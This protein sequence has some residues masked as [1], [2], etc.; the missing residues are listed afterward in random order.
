MCAALFGVVFWDAFLELTAL[1]SMVGLSAGDTE[2]KATNRAHCS[3]ARL[4]L[5]DSRTAGKSWTVHHI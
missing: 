2:G 1:S 3:L 5:N 4:L